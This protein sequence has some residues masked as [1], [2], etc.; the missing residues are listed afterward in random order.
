MGESVRVPGRIHGCAGARACAAHLGSFLL[1]P[2]QLRADRVLTGEW[3]GAQALGLLEEK[4]MQHTCP[5][6]LGE[7]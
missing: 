5:T 2:W 4:H 7:A 6:L 3:G 1:L